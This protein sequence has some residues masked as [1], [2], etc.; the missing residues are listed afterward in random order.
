M[1]MRDLSECGEHLSTSIY[2]KTQRVGWLPKYQNALK[3]FHTIHNS[4]FTIH[5]NASTIHE[6]FS[7]NS[8]STI[9]EIFSSNSVSTIHNT[10]HDFFFAT[11]KSKNISVGLRTFLVPTKIILDAFQNNSGLVIFICEKQPKRF[12]QLRN[13]SGFFL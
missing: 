2:R 8:V 11:V 5:N 7:P 4:V 12:R 13:I 9:R 3:Y 1:Y 10:I 6:I